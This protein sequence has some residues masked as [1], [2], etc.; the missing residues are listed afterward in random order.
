MLESSSGA[1]KDDSDYV[2][3]R[4]KSPEISDNSTELATLIEEILL[5]NN[6]VNTALE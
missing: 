6:D 3:S 5:M 1:N 2:E 4:K